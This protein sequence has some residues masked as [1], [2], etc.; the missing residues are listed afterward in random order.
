MPARSSSTCSTW[1][2]ITLKGTRALVGVDIRH[3]CRRQDRPFRRRIRATSATDTLKLIAGTA[4]ISGKAAVGL[5]SV[6][7]IREDIFQAKIGDRA[8]VTVG[9][10]LDV[11]A[12]SARCINLIAGGGLG[13]RQ[14]RRGRLADR[15]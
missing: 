11:I 15:C 7:A 14:D 6:T 4:G 1:A 12:R 2:P 10:G 5:A 3:Q 13:R 8:Q 9:K